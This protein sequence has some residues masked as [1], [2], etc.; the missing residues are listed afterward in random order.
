MSFEKTAGLEAR[1]FDFVISKIH[2]KYELNVRSLVTDGAGQYRAARSILSKRHPTKFFL[3]CWAHK[4]HNIVKKFL[5]QTGRNNTLFLSPF[6]KF[7]WLGLQESV[8]NKAKDIVSY[9]HKSNRAKNS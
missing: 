4:V 3:E 7:V 2:D 9:Y 8:L 1:K 6:S 5:E